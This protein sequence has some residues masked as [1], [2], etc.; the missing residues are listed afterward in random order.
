MR[1]IQWTRCIR[2]RSRADAGTVEEEE[3][4]RR[5]EDLASNTTINPT[6]IAEKQV[7]NTKSLSGVERSRDVAAE[8]EHLPHE[9]HP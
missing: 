4:R 3:M 8:I 9:T 1:M 7:H 2:R 6:D 5:P